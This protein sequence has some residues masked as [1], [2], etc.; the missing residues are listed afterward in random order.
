M[1]S[2]NFTVHYFH[3]SYRQKPN[4]TSF[5]QLRKAKVN[6]QRLFLALC[7]DFPLFLLAA[8][9][10]SLLHWTDNFTILL[11]SLTSALPVWTAPMS[12]KNITGVGLCTLMSAGFF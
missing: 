4:V 10:S 9:K 7:K 3:F 5:P 12:H 2:N 6:K 1:L 8:A 11:T